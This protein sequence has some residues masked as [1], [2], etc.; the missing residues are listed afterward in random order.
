MGI[1]DAIFYLSVKYT[2]D[3]LRNFIQVLHVYVTGHR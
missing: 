2:E 1:S 3:N